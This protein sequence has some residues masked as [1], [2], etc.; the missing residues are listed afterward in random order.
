MNGH[1][2]DFSCRR[3][4]HIAAHFAPAATDKRQ[5]FGQRRPATIAEF[6]RQS[7][8]MIQRFI[9]HGAKPRPKILTAFTKHTAEEGKNRHCVSQVAEPRQ[10]RRHAAKLCV[11][12]GMCHKTRVKRFGAAIA[13]QRIERVL[14]HVEQW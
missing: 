2:P 6:L 1:D 14:I 13:G 11:C 9:N 8:K 10:S 7:Q 12:P 4:I 3:C 5:K